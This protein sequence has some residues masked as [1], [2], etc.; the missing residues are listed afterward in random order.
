MEKKELEKW[1]KQFEKSNLTHL[2]VVS[3]A[4][5]LKLSK[6]NT[7]VAKKEEVSSSFLDLVSPLVG[8]FYASSS[9]TNP[10]FVKAGDPVKK[11]QIIGIVEAMKIM[12]EIHA[13]R[14]GI[15]KQILVENRQAVGFHQVLMRME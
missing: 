5:T 9:P 2:E 7:P 8:T 13:P 15:I 11:G 3:D 6:E 4:F 10:P 12:N 14:D 1:I